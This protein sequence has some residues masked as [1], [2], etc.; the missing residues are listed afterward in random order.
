MN[1]DVLEDSSWDIALQ[2]A[3]SALDPNAELVRVVRSAWTGTPSLND[4]SRGLRL[5]TVP[6]SAVI[7]AAQMLEASVSTIEAAISTL[8]FKGAATVAAINFTS[9]SIARQCASPRLQDLIL[10]QMIDQIE[11]GYHFGVIAEDIGPDTGM[12]LGFGQALGAALLLAASNSSPG[13]AKALFE[14][15]ETPSAQLRR[16]GCEPY[17][18]ASLALQRLG[19]GPSTASAAVM[20]L[21]NFSR[22]VP[23]N[24]PRVKTWW[25]ASEWINALA[26]GERTPSRRSSALQYPDLLFDIETQTAIPLHLEALYTSVDAVLTQHSVWTWHLAESPHSN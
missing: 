25:A 24:D 4:C 14:G 26:R 9:S 2:R 11:V 3:R 5:A 23:A 1:T 7:E 17:Q 15:S 16:F 21:G 20:S 22:E 19:F 8:S 10:Q 18:V 6:F 12:L 13:D